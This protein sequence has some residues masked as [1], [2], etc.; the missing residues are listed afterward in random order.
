MQYTRLIAYFLN[1]NIV[2]TTFDRLCNLKNKKLI[3]E[4]GLQIVI[5]ILEMDNSE[6]MEPSKD[7]AFYVI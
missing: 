6:S 3:P 1:I 5:S 7:Y 4:R 2:Q